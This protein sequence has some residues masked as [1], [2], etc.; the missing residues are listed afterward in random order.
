MF[1]DRCWPVLQPSQRPKRELLRTSMEAS[2]ASREAAL[3]VR[4]GFW[5]SSRISPAACGSRFSDRPHRERSP[6]R[7]QVNR[8]SLLP[9]LRRSVLLRPLNHNR[10]QGRK[11]QGTPSEFTVATQSVPTLDQMAQEIRAGHLKRETDQGDRELPCS[12]GDCRRGEGPAAFGK[13]FPCR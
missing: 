2:S 4:F 13:C 8:R 10:R 11:P 7:E 5:A 12:C 3:M 1:S 6:N 9:P